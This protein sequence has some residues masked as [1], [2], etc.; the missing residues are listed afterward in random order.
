MIFKLGEWIE[1]SKEEIKK[2]RAKSG[3]P[4]NQITSLQTHAKDGCGDLHQILLYHHIEYF[5]QFYKII[6]LVDR[7]ARFFFGGEAR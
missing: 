2:V 5:N 1:W 4:L 7:V 6:E 3:G